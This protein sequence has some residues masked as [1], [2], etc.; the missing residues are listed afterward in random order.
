MILLSRNPKS[1]ETLG[2]SAFEDCANEDPPSAMRKIELP[3]GLREIGSWCFSDVSYLE[4]VSIPSSVEKIGTGA[5]A[6]CSGLQ[7]VDVDTDNPNYSAYEGA[8]YS[9]SG[10][11]LY[12][13]PAGLSAKRFTLPEWC[14]EIGPSAFALSSNL[15][16]LTLHSNVVRI[17]R[18]AFAGSTIQQMAIPA[19]VGA[20]PD[21]AFWGC[22]R[23]ETLELPDNLTSIGDRAFRGCSA[24]KEL[25]LPKALRVV[26]DE[27]FFA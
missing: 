14:R 12:A 21:D 11:T 24:L 22:A 3:E 8:L 25:A 4:Y 18:G 5:F 19:S 9:R 23:L 10:A 20:I 1:V 2:D 15:R 27:A 26:G 13:Y 7:V 17:G 16:E 6:F